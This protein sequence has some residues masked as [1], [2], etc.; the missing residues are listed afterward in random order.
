MSPKRHA[1]FD[2]EKIVPLVRAIGR[3]MRERTFAIAELEEREAAL[4]P[5]RS[6][7]LDELRRIESELSTHRREL[8]RV[9]RELAELGCNLDADH[10]LRILIPSDGGAI[11]YEGQLDGT[12]F[13]RVAPTAA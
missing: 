13:Y 10:P 7:H 6:A 3:E 2:A 9:E 4:A 1:R 5:H 12:R 8:R 11:A